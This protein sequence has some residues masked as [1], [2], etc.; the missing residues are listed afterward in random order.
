MAEWVAAETAMLLSAHAAGVPVLGVCFGGQLLA[1]AHGG[2]VVRAETSEIGW[3]TLEFSDLVG[4][5]PWFQ[6][7]FDRWVLPPGAR[8]IAR[9]ANA[10]QAFLLGTTMAVQFHP[11]LDRGLLEV[12]L[13]EDRDGAVVA[14]G[15]DVDELRAVTDREA[16]VVPAR[17]DALVRGFCSDARRG[18]T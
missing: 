13:D 11:E 8:E 7:H 9:T 17:I 14:H 18:D 10:S 3:Y 5:G 12:W 16:A 15:L 4:P 2:S 1:A 6:W